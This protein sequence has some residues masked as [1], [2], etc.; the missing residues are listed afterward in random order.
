MTSPVS[1]VCSYC[2]AAFDVPGGETFCPSCWAWVLEI[3]DYREQQAQLQAAMDAR[4]TGA[5]DK[6]TQS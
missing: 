6:K 1:W 4:R 5:A 2:H 3:R